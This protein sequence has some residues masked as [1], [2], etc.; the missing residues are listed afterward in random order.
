MW[1]MTAARRDAGAAFVGVALVLTSLVL[2]WAARLSVPGVVYVSGLGATG[3]PTARQF[4]TA[5][6][7]IVAGGS[8][9]AFAGRHVRSGL[10]VLSAWTPAISLWIACGFFLVASQ[11]TCTPGCPTPL[12]PSF[13]WQDFT[14]I[15]C[16]VFAFAASCWAMLQSSFV[17]DHRALSRF[18]IAMGASVAVIASAGGILSLVNFATDVGSKLELV[19]TSLAIGWVAVY[20]IS[21]AARRLALIQ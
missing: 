4:E 8:L 20:G 10:R 11:V 2:I 19:A 17:R 16:A 13:D 14:H 18:S 9:I 5:L 6:L 12:G 21:T 15:V 7:L 1:R 3:M